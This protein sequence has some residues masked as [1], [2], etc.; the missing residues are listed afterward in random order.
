MM[1]EIEHLPDKP[2][3]RAALVRLMGGIARFSSASITDD[4]T[5]DN[6]LQMES[7]TF[8][9]LQVAIEDEFDIELDPIQ[10]VELNAFGAIVDYVNELVR[11]EKR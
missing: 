1:P 4:A 6:E 11:S 10:V 5:I 9:E 2:E 7:V 8:V 3:I